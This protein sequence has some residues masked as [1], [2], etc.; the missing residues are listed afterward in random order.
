MNAPQAIPRRH[1]LRSCALGS[2]AL[3]TIDF[4]RQLFAESPGQAAD[5]YRG[6]KMGVASYS[7][8]KFTL[9]QA[10]DMTR[11]LGLKYIC[12]KDMHLPLTSTK[13]ECQAAHDKVTAD[14]LTLLGGGVITIR[15]RD[16]VRNIFQYAKNAGMPTIVS[17][18]DPELLDSVEEMVKEFDIRLAIHNHGPGDKWYPSPSDA[19]RAIENRDKRMGLCIDVGHT[20]RIGEEPV[21][22]IQRCAGRLYDFH[23]KDVSEATAKG[24]P[25]VLGTGIIDIPAVL[26]ALLAAGFTGH[27]GLEYERDADDPMPGMQKSLAYIRSSIAA[28]G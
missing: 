25:V 17:S 9:D 14:G 28:M 8:R 24:T 26:K 18:P 12:L 16:D 2:A 1:F 19:L 11:E 27:L 4:P 6:L 13:A 20:V 23:I 15:K 10:L 7:L 5:P 22:A 21:A 3:A